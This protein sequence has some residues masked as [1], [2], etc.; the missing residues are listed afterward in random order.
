MT[1]N[2][3]QIR[4]LIERWKMKVEVVDGEEKLQVTPP[5]QQELNKWIN[6]IKNNK[7]LIINEIKKIKA[8]EEQR[9]ANIEAI[10]GLRELQQAI[11][12]KLNYRY[13]WNRRMEDEALSSI[14]PEKPAVSVVE[15]KAK[16]P[17]AAA[18]ITAEGW[19][20]SSNSGKRQAG[21]KALE[22][23]IAGENHEQVLADMEAEWSEYVRARMWD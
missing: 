11:N 17:R 22:R 12:D 3:E 6:H 14:M 9:K 4:T 16:Y 5:S 20:R 8:E 23:I 19:S 13:E 21:K 18:Y 2:T 15:L 7:T 10:E 1:L